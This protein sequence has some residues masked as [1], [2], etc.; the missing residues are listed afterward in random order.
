MSILSIQFS[1]GGTSAGQ[2][3]I[4]ESG[5][6]TDEGPTRA[7]LQ[8]FE[9]GRVEIVTLPRRVGVVAKSL[10]GHNLSTRTIADPVTGVLTTCLQLGRT[11]FDRFAPVQ[12]IGPFKGKN[13]LAYRR[14]WLQLDG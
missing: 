10:E 9:T 12:P 13:I 6:C 4:I 7:K 8:S 3:T 1:I 5:F 11:A 2:R 14:T